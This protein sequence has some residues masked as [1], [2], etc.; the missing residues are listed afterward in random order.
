MITSDL[1]NLL[2]KNYNFDVKKNCESLKD[3]EKMLEIIAVDISDECKKQNQQ[4]KRS[5]VIFA[6]DFCKV[7]NHEVFT[8][9][10]LFS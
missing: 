5:H 6:C 7:L 8:Y 10:F 4:V 9:E 1:N 2:L 3:L